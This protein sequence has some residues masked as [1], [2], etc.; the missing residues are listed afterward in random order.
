[1]LSRNTEGPFVRDLASHM[2]SFGSFSPSGLN[3]DLK[4]VCGPEG[5]AFGLISVIFHR[6]N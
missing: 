5:E 1:M 6:Q 3:L 4:F 2:Y